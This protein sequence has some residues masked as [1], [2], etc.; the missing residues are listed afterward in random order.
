MLERRA[1]E[2]GVRIATR[3]KVDVLPDPPVIIAAELR[4][5]GR[6]A[7]TEDPDRPHPA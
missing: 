3:R 7:G 4:S 6:L 2:P 5:A 1:R